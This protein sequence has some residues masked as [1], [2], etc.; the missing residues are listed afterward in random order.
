MYIPNISRLD[1]E[2]F[3]AKINTT[4]RFWNNDTQRGQA[5]NQASQELKDSCKY[6]FMRD[7]GW[8]IASP[9][10]EAAFQLWPEDWSYIYV[11]DDY[12]S[13]LDDAALI[14]TARDILEARQVTEEDMKQLRE[15]GRKHHEGN[16]SK[17]SGTKS[18]FMKMMDRQAD[19]SG[20]IISDADPG[21]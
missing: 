17:W 4:V 20:Q 1:A 10:Y 11:L 19:A 5:D 8:S 21:L 3:Q 18:E 6:I 12:D 9:D 15:R 7:D 2:Q 16:R 13:T 14:S